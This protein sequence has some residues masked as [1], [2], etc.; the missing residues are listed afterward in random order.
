VFPRQTPSFC[1]RSSR[2]HTLRR[3]TDVNHLLFQFG[4]TKEKLPLSVVFGLAALVVTLL[5]SILASWGRAGSLSLSW[6]AIMFLDAFSEEFLFGG[7]L[8]LYL[9]RLTDVK[10][11]YATSL[12]AFILAYPHHFD[13]LFI[14]ATT[15]QGTLLALVTHKTNNIV[16]PWIS[17][18]SNRVF[19]NALGAL[20]F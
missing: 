5:M 9:F 20:L 6:S 8:F 15:A 3:K 14:A 18:G 17:H 10:I 7:V 11:A 2:F 16:G 19:A 4:I 13:S 12:P 1:C